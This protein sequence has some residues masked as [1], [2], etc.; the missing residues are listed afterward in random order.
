[1]K[2]KRP[3]LIKIKPKGVMCK[4]CKYSFGVDIRHNG[5][6]CIPPDSSKSHMYFGEHSCGNGEP[7]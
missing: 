4:D 7:R 6:Y 3:R 1:M 5:Y 2:A